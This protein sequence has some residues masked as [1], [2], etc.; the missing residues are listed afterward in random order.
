[1]CMWTRK[2]VR[3]R[4]AVAGVVGAMLVGVI[5]VVILSGPAS[6]ATWKVISS[7]TSCTTYSFGTLCTKKATSL[8]QEKYCTKPSIKNPYSQMSWATYCLRYKETTHWK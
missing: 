1:M 5:P 4:R 8:R 2:S 7:K 3:M 6:A